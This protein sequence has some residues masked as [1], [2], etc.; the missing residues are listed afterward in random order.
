MNNYTTATN[1][2][3][4]VAAGFPTSCDLCHDAVLWTDG[5]F[6]HS[7]TG[8]PLTGFHLTSTQC[9]QCH[10]N[11]NYNLTSGHTFCSSC[12]MNNYTTTKNPQN[13]VAHGLPTS[14]HL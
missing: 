10:V 13:H 6:N 5:K 12:L 2:V 11:N 9:S 8:W 4:H 7:T 1:P 14:G 3:N